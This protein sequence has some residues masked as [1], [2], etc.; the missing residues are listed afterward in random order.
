MAVSG[1]ARDRHVLTCGV[2]GLLTGFLAAYCYY[3]PALRVLAHSLG[4]WVLAVVVVAART[5]VRRAGARSVAL[6]VGAVA[7]FY[8]GKKVFYG[9]KYPGMP[10]HVSVETVVL[11]CGFAGV[12]GLLL[13]VLFHAIGADTWPGA[14]AASAAVGLLVADAIRKDGFTSDHGLPLGA[15]TLAGVLVVLT[16]QGFRP[17]RL[18]RFAVLVVPVTVASWVVVHLPDAIEAVVL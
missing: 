13:G 1:V 14:F 12:A 3:W 9:I 15:V 8:V 4:P 18:K 11:W 6:L 16:R 2:A 5:D 7:A 10:Y 17:D